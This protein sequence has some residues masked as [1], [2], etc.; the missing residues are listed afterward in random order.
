MEPIIPVYL[1][2]L[3]KAPNGKLFRL[4][5]EFLKDQLPEGW[6]I[7]IKAPLPDRYWAVE[8]ITRWIDFKKGE[9]Q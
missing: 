7:A 2:D 4:S 3:V 5:T 1:Y 6:S 9:K 8:R